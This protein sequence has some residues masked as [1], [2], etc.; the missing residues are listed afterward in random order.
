LAMT[1]PTTVTMIPITICDIQLRM[2]CLACPTGAD[3]ALG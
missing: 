3:P 1:V 2:R